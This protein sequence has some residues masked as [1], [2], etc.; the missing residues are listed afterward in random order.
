MMK[1]HT[2]LLEERVTSA[3]ER[4]KELSAERERLETEVRTLQTRLR[5]AEREKSDRTDGSPVSGGASEGWPEQRAVI[6]Q[7]LKETIADL[8]TD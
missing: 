2:K 8:R 1:D 5:I 3:V 6:I 7:T 4:L